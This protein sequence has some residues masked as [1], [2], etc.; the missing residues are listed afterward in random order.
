MDQAGHLSHHL[1][2]LLLK[3][4]FISAEP[5]T[6]CFTGTFT[7]FTMTSRKLGSVSPIL[8]MR[9]LKLREVVISLRSHSCQPSGARIH[10]QYSVAAKVQTLNCLANPLLHQMGR[11]IP[12]LQ[13]KMLKRI[14]Q[15]PKKPQRRPRL[16]TQGCLAPSLSLRDDT[17][18][19]AMP[20]SPQEK[21]GWVDPTWVDGEAACP[22]HRAKEQELAPGQVISLSGPQS[23]Q[24]SKKCQTLV[25]SGRPLKTPTTTGGC[26]LSRSP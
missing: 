23:P 20:G 4:A 15:L 25:W 6:M 5:P 21:P 7:I 24:V 14:K 19:G 12:I 3:Q 17:Q 2:A 10:K 16:H 8:Q 13:R 9:K 1:L 18:V 11:G 22:C 26:V